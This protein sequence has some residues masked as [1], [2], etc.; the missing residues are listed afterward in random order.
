VKLS[1]CRDAYRDLSA[2]ASDISRTLALAA[3]ALVWLFKSDGPMGPAIPSLLFWPI[4]LIVSA[5]SAD[6][7]Q[8]MWG[9]LAFGVLGRAK[10]RHGVGRD[11]EFVAPRWINWPATLLFWVK[12]VL[13]VVAYALILKFLRSHI[14]FV[15]A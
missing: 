3:V 10:E 1:E 13:V 15:P 11:Q 5:L 14:S 6:L 8:Y 2:R 4:S 12:L 9:A 7:L